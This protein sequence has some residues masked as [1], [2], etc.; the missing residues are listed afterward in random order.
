MIAFAD[1]S[2]VVKLYADE[3]GHHAVRRLRAMAVSQLTRVEVPA[4]LWRKHRMGEL[5]AP[6]A[7]VLTAA[8]EADWHGTDDEPPRFSAVTLTQAILDDAAHLC[9]VHGLRAYDAVQLSSALAARRADPSCSTF[10]VVDGTLRSAASAEG[11][12]TD[13]AG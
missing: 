8:F 7:R 4:A 11:F 3:H 12:A 6:E 5:G 1:A 9:A 2:A 10:A 13:L